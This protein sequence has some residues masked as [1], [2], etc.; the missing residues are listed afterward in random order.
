MRHVQDVQP[1]K[2]PPEAPPSAVCPSV[3]HV[4]SDSIP[5][6]ERSTSTSQNPAAA[7]LS[8]QL[9][10]QHAF[11]VVRRTGSPTGENKSADSAQP[12][13]LQPSLMVGL[14]E[15]QV[16]PL[17]RT[18]WDPVSQDADGDSLYSHPV[19]DLQST[20]MSP[21]VTPGSDTRNNSPSNGKATGPAGMTPPQPQPSRLQYSTTAAEFSQASD[22][23]P[24]CPPAPAVQQEQQPVLGNA[25]EPQMAAGQLASKPTLHQ[26]LEAVV[27][28]RAA[29]AQRAAG[30]QVQPPAQ[31]LHALSER[32]AAL[33]A[34]LAGNQPGS[35]SS[36]DGG[37]TN[38]HAFGSDNHMMA[39]AAAA[40]DKS[41]AAGKLA[42]AS[43]PINLS[44][45]SFPGVHTG[46]REPVGGASRVAPS[47]PPFTKPSG[48]RPVQ[49]GGKHAAAGTVTAP[50]LPPEQLPAALAYPVHATITRALSPSRD[51]P[52]NMSPTQMRAPPAA[53]RAQPSPA[54]PQSA[55]A[56]ARQASAYE[57]HV[58]RLAAKKAA[59]SGG[60]HSPSPSAGGAASP[61]PATMRPAP[62]HTF[63]SPREGA[64]DT[65]NLNMPRCSDVSTAPPARPATAGSRPAAAAVAIC[66]PVR[67]RS[68]SAPKTRAGGTPSR[69]GTQGR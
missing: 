55:P 48:Q 27:S 66:K 41:T 62:A 20:P 14:T 54:R 36:N 33:R 65:G 19:H 37:S 21:H 29:A 43:H 35:S 56:R 26:L 57:A 44:S 30:S 24:A 10:H 40:S 47:P 18:S 11:V 61:A 59:A 12:N 22:M 63:A 49:R 6:V 15:G 4:L 31:L 8:D 5:P 7:A 60:T 16:A 2:R 45:G 52:A 53:Q 51:M 64:A 17:T 34:A 38:H 13:A 32:V 23:D 9:D 50:L 25:S 1:W 46:N 42:T 28:A 3:M 67:G 58:A 69:S 68:A 39:Q